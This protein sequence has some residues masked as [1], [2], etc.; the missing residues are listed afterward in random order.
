MTHRPTRRGLQHLAFAV[1]TGTALTAAAGSAHAADVPT[2]V[3]TNYSGTSS[4]M[5]LHLEINVP[6]AVSINQDISLASTTLAKASSDTA[7]A[8]AE[9]FHSGTGS[10]LAPVFDALDQTASASL[11]GDRSSSKPVSPS[12]PD[13]T[14]LTQ[15]AGGLVTANVLPNTVA[16][17]GA[18]GV[19]NVAAIG[20]GLS[21]PALS[22]ALD[23]AIS[24]LNAAVT[25]VSTGVTS[26]LGTVTGTV[27]GLVPTTGTPVDQLQQTVAD[28]PAQLQAAVTSI[29]TGLTGI[30]GI[31]GALSLQGVTTT[32]SVTRGVN[33]V[34]SSAGAKIL[35]IDV[36]GGLV[37][38]EGTNSLVT[39]TATGAAGSAVS[40]EQSP[41]VA[42]VSIGSLAAL[43][44]TVDGL[45]VDVA[46]VTLP[47]ATK[48]ALQSVISQ[49]NALLALANV[50]IVDLGHTSS[51]AAD[52]SAAS[53][54]VSGLGITVG[55]LAALNAL[56]ANTDAATAAAADAAPL[57]S[58]TLSPATA[59]AAAERVIPAVVPAAPAAPAVVTPKLAYTGF[60]GELM[61][62]TAVT[63]ILGAGYLRRRRSSV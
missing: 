11:S 26:T 35:G 5:G 48:T 41:Q 9:A 12:V 13:P 57:I 52:G 4:A 31:G 54:T 40:T 60:D 47:D 15:I 21:N 24:S 8:T 58:I 38:I 42:A 18:T 43:Q 27:A 2:T 19:S 16:S 1:A 25:T 39:A 46:G 10:L 55:S 36:L 14:N 22:S 29:Q 34:T 20:V 45:T 30:T 17:F 63:L 53:A 32:S 59:S 51:T 49:L 6:G 3:P 33:S 44:S 7:T 23:S 50:R 56:N 61:A 62:G 28:L 37:H